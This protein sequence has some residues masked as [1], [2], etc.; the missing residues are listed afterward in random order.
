MQLDFL[1]QELNTGYPNLVK[2]LKT[3]DE[4]IIVNNCNTMDC[5]ID[6]SGLGYMNSLNS[7]EDDALKHLEY[8][9][10]FFPDIKRDTDNKCTP[11]E[12]YDL[13][14]NKYTSGKITTLIG[15]ITTFPYCLDDMGLLVSNGSFTNKNTCAYSKDTA[16]YMG[17]IYTGNKNSKAVIGKNLFFVYLYGTNEFFM[18]LKSSCDPNLKESSSLQYP[19]GAGCLQKIMKDGWKINY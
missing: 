1:F 3:F 2:L 11:K 5:V 13:S 4:A 12:I 15:N 17:Y 16:C 8:M 6:S 9:K 19:N 10:L 14:G 7:T 18:N